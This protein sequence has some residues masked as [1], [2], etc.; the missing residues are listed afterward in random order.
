[1][2]HPRLVVLLPCC[3]VFPRDRDHF[4]VRSC[5]SLPTSDKSGRFFSSCYFSS[6]NDSAAHKET[7]FSAIARLLTYGLTRH[8]DSDRA[9]HRSP[10]IISSPFLSFCDLRHGLWFFTKHVTSRSGEEFSRCARTLSGK[11]SFALA[12]CARWCTGTR[13]GANG[14]DNRVSLLQD[15]ESIFRRQELAWFRY[16]FISCSFI[17]RV[18]SVKV[19]ETRFYQQKLSNYETNKRTRKSEDRVL[20]TWTCW[21]MGLFIE[22][23]L[24]FWS[25]EYFLN[26]ETRWLGWLRSDPSL[27]RR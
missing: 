22:H 12:T 21:G 27:E 2:Q 19:I 10:I 3:C 11:I 14:V 1:M 25:F 8:S 17:V 13:A 4:A 18:V 5:S 20:D 6:S 9:F 7:W 24:I 26:T 16:G 23:F 15:I